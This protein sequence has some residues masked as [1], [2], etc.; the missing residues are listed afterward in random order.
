MTND[1]LSLLKAK[2]DDIVANIDKCMALA[3][4]DPTRALQAIDEAR[5]GMQAL[6]YRI[7]EAHHI[8]GN[9]DAR[10]AVGSWAG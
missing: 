4:D 10:R 7:W 3:P 1:E 2:R 8:R 6:W 9:Q 5:K